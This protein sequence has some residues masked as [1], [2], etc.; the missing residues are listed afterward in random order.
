MS[1][2]LLV[3]GLVLATLPAC[4]GFEVEAQ[5]G[6][7]Q[8]ALDGDLGYTSGANNVAV[9]QDIE[10]AFGLGDDQGTPFLRAKMD[11][12][13]PVLSVSAFRFEDE[14]TGRLEADFGDVPFIPGGTPVASTVDL[15]S[16][17]TALAFDIP[18]GPVTLSPGIAVDYVDLDIN[19]RDLI[20]IASEQ[21]ELQA[22][23]PLLF[24]RG[25]VDLG[26]VSG[27]LEIGYA[28]VDI[29]DVEAALLDVE[30]LAIVRPTEL[31]ELFVGYRLISLEVDGEVDGDTVD[32][33]LELSGWMIGGGVRF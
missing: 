29:D 26:V 28:A 30:A 25:Q 8:L 18:L 1:I 13:V 6:Y 11:L 19:V 21:V 4:F 16:A 23:L 33:D 10:S 14:G 12:G 7:S 27:V 5:A 15:L 9:S 24:A 17:K 2:R 32:A 31:L 22:P 3:A 20:G